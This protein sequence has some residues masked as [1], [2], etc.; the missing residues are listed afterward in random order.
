MR[1]AIKD[2]SHLDRK[3]GVEK[4]QNCRIL[5]RRS[6]IFSI[7]LF[8]ADSCAVRM[9]E[10]YRQHDQYTE[11]HLNRA[12]KQRRDRFAS[13]L[14]YLR[15]EICSIKKPAEQD[16]SNMSPASI[17]LPILFVSA[18]WFIV[19]KRYFDTVNLLI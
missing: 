4:S 11:T 19:H 18:S 6:E 16:N 8:R 17:L 10:V 12:L 5:T 7:W 15:I 1:V 14:M 3:V 13:N 2:R 9:S